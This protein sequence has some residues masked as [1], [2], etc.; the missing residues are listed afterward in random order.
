M[1][2]GVEGVDWRPW[3]T[4]VMVV[5]GTRKGSLDIGVLRIL[6]LWLFSFSFFF[7]RFYISLRSIV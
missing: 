4:V 3:L 7:F 5:D 1:L 6:R 2:L